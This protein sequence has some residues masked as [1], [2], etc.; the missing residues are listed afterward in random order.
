MA[1][2]QDILYKVNIRTVQGRLEIPVLSIQTDSRRDMNGAAFIA[3]KGVHADGHQFIA[4]A[5]QK[6]AIAVICEEMP[7][8]QAEGVTY[9]QV[10][11]SAVAAGLMAHNFFGQP[12]EKLK[13]VGV[14]GTNGK[15]T[16]VTL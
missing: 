15:T 13:L 1:L 12:S 2:L 10:E 7:P 14:T 4:T 11:R 5:V 6:G 8:A 16:I 3:V 9:V